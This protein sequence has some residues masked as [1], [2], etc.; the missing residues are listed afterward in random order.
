[1]ARKYGRLM[2]DVWDDKD[3]QALSLAEQGLFCGLLAH[4]KISWVGVIDYIPSR[5]VKISNGLTRD[6][7]AAGLQQLINR[8]LLC[9][10]EETEEILVRR[11]MHYDGVLTVQNM[12][13]AMVAAYNSVESEF[14]KGIIVGELARIWDDQPALK[15]WEG[16]QHMAPDFYDEILDRAAC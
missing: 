3:Y 9:F 12:G 14:L 11:F 4:P 16:V 8:G 6:A 1:M 15:G 10:D 7:L 2:V 13:K 5:L